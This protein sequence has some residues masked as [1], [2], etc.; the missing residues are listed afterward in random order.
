MW[1]IKQIL[2]PV[3]FSPALERVLP[4][5][6]GLARTHGARLHLLH[7]TM[8]LEQCAGL[9]DL[10]PMQ[11]GFLEGAQA[12]MD[13]LC[14]GPLAGVAGLTALVA[15]GD[16]VEKILAYAQAQGIDLIVVGT[17]GHKGLKHAILGS[18]AENLVRRSPVPVLTINPHRL[19]A[20][21]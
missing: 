3:D 21:G 15:C 11:A 20:P 1:A 17:H 9:Y 12:K 6:L 10:G 14:Q 5:V 8:D 18:V 13:A 7:V 2:W 16:P 4:Y 19:A